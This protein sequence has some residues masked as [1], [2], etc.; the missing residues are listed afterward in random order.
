V[1]QPRFSVVSAVYNV[2]RYLPDYIEAI[3]NQTLDGRLIEVVAVDDG[4]T[5]DSLDVLRAW[6]AKNPERVKVLTKPNGGQGSARNLG[7]TVA[8][9]EWVTFTDPDDILRPDYFEQVETFL[10]EHPE[11]EMVATARHLFYE[12]LDEVR[13]SHP[14]AQHFADGNQLVD[15]RRSPQYFMGSAPAAIMKLDRIREVGLTFD[16]RIKPNFEDGHFCSHY[17]LESPAPLVGFVADAHYLYR[18]RADQSS[19]LQNSLMHPGRFTSVVEHGYLEVLQFAAARNDGAAPDWLQHF[20]L[21]ELS[22]YFSSEELASNAMTAAVGEVAERFH[23]LMKQ[24]VTYI[25]PWNVEAHTV[26]TYRTTWRDALLHGWSD[27]DWRTPFAVLAKVDAPLGLVRV[28]YRYA[29]Q[30]P[31]EQFL[32]GGMPIAPHHAKTRS[33]VYF[34]KTL[35]YERVAWVSGYDTLSVRLDHRPLELRTRWPQPPK[36]ELTPRLA[37]NQR[38]AAGKPAA[39]LST[40]ARVRRVASVVKHRAAGAA[41]SM[42]PQRSAATHPAPAADA[43]AFAKA[44]VFVDRLHDADD[45]AEHLFRY[46]RDTRPDINAW[47]VI[48]KGTVDWERITADGYGERLV[49]PYTQRWLDLMVNC[50]YLISSHADLPIR[51]PAAVVEHMEPKWKFVFLQHG[52]IKDDL[53]NWLN[54]M[55]IALFITST[56][57]EYASIAG[58]FNRYAYSTNEVVLTEL[59][60]FDRLVARDREYPPEKRDYILVAPTWRHWLTPPLEQGSQRRTVYEGFEDTEYAQNWL[61]LLRSEAVGSAARDRGLKLG[62]LPHPNLQS[63]LATLDL[64]DLVVPLSYE[65]ADIQ[66]M[67]ARA[68]MLV[69][70]YSSVAFNAAYIERPVVYFQFD[71]ETMFSGGHVGRQGYFEYPDQGF[72]PV[73]YDLAAAEAAVVAT[74]D[75]G[76]VP[77]SPYRE[78]IHGAFPYRD[79]NACERVLGSI[80][81]LGRRLSAAEALTRVPAPQP[82]PLD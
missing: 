58:D 53:A 23:A 77:A 1:T 15:L 62:F 74:L 39:P 31:Q 21:Y 32:S 36:L 66:G 37:K 42:R 25:D 60:R 38:R 67:F 18:K 78:R 33:L 27:E 47:F 50:V 80:E 14:L 81:Q 4:S 75:H 29:G 59:P 63:V 20:I 28:T 71:A 69:T 9:G 70:D 16:E 68:A 49:A 34:D 2:A 82:R 13:D 46:V 72:G 24:I 56:H 22:W 19:T 54:P 73:A 7:L 41:G 11:T 52:V 5:D 26:R 79:G 12:D 44:W 40:K 43:P 17:V 30:A 35:V 65:G 61:G 55:D 3:E 57:N 48:E 6:E 64:P 45:S 51:R 76:P 8:T 10:R